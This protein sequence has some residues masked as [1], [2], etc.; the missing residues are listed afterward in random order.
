[1]KRHSL[2]LRM[3]ALKQKHTTMYQNRSFITLTLF[4]SIIQYYNGVNIVAEIFY[5]EVEAKRDKY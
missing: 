1:M 5:S 3:H 4:N 2:K